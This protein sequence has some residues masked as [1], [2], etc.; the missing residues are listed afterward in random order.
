LSP[1]KEKRPE[2]K[3]NLI[4]ELKHVN[5]KKRDICQGRNA[6]TAATADTAAVATTP[7]SS[8]YIL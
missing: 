8:G 7:G 6:F 3:V 4:H 5:F 1:R 2:Q